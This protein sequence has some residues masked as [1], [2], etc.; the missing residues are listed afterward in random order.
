VVLCLVLSIAG[1]VGAVVLLVTPTGF[2]VAALAAAAVNA[3]LTPY[4]ALVV[5][6]YYDEV[7]EERGSEPG[8]PEGHPVAPDATTAASE[9]E[10]RTP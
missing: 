5:A 10:P 3:F 1:L 7:L 6:H 9:P 8:D 4:A 2:A